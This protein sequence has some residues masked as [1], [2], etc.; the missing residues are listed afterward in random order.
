MGN[1]FCDVDWPFGDFHRVATLHQGVV[2]KV[3]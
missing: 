3:N 1:E 2:E